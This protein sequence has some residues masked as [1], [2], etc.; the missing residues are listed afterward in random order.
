MKKVIAAMAAMFLAVVPLG[1]VW[2]ILLR[3]IIG[4]G[5]EQSFL[6]PIYG[7]LILLAGLIVGSAAV[8]REEFKK[9]QAGRHAPAGEMPPEKESLEKESSKKEPSKKESSKKELPK[10]APLK[11]EPSNL[12]LEEALEEFPFLADLVC[13]VGGKDY[14]QGVGSDRI[15]WDSSM[16]QFRRTYQLEETRTFFLSSFMDV[17]G[18]IIKYSLDVEAGNDS[19]YEI[20]PEKM[21]QLVRIIKVMYPSA[22]PGPAESCVCYLGQHRGWELIALA[23]MNGLIDKEFHY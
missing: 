14:H 11:K 21:D 17:K 20:L 22:P 1:G 16:K 23:E 10:K 5:V 9:L 3:P 4:G 8:L 2:G 12:T 13:K 18:I 19:Y 7:G 15:S 6:Y